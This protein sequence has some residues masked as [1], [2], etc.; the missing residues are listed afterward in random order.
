MHAL[1]QAPCSYR[2]YRS[3][4][5]MAGCRACTCAVACQHPQGCSCEGVPR[6][7]RSRRTPLRTDA[8]PIFD[9]QHASTA[10]LSRT[11]RRPES[12]TRRAHATTAS[13][14]ARC[15]AVAQ[16]SP[17]L[18]IRA[19]V[20]R[21][22]RRRSYSRWRMGARHLPSAVW[23]PHGTH[24]ERDTSLGVGQGRPSRHRRR[25]PLIS[26]SQRPFPHRHTTCS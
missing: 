9:L 25:N 3:R 18:R 19:A 4:S 17:A 16:T 8:G 2:L 22:M 15:C 10:P 7:A 20:E 26:G 21:N 5:Y 6:A 24:R 11:R 1:S 12:A 14:C 13:R 23:S